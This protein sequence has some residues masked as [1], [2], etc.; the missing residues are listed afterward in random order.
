M[1]FVWACCLFVTA[2]CTTAASQKALNKPNAAEDSSYA[3]FNR[4]AADKSKRKAEL[5]EPVKE[6]TDPEKAVAIL[7]ERL[8]KEP[9]IAI[10]AE[11]QL[12]YWG[13]RAG[14]R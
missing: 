4:D 3:G 10:P 12:K 14:R 9:S 7:T 1:R 8:Q 13:S 5:I 2:G 11:E 6:D